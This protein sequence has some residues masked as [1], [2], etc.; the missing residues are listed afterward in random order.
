MQLNEANN[1]NVYRKVQF[2]TDSEIKELR[3]VVQDMDLNAYTSNPNDDIDAQGI[4][5]HTTEYVNTNNLFERSLPWLH[6]RAFQLIK[7]VN[8]EENWGF[9]LTPGK[10]N[11]RV[12]EYHEMEIGGTL[13]NVK[14][15]DIG[16]LITLD[17]M[18]EEP[19]DGA[20]FQTMNNDVVTKQTF[21]R[22]DALVFVSHKYHHVT[23]LKQGSR[24]VFVVEY[25]TGAK[26]TCGHRCDKRAGKC[27]FVDDS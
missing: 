18:L 5:V 8:K 20:Y 27:G 24:K 6:A 9:D 12:A 16:S 3:D 14:H 17:I 26:R 23:Q 22:G 25:W 13:S 10:V 21:H 4:P 1:T 15:F 19:I 7:H 11:V 2:L